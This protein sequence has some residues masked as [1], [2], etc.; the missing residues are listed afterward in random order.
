[1]R[2]RKK[3]KPKHQTEKKNPIPT[4]TLLINFSKFM[5]HQFEINCYIHYYVHTC[6]NYIH[7]YVLYI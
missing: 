1:M 4:A 2:L 6:Y 7:K 3:T 5:M